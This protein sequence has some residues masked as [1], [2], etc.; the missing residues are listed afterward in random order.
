MPPFVEVAQRL[1]ADMDSTYDQNSL[2]LTNTRIVHVIVWSTGIRMRRFINETNKGYWE[3]NLYTISPS[4]RWVIT[5]EGDQLWHAQGK[6]L[7][8]QFIEI[9][10]AKTPWTGIVHLYRRRD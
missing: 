8:T 5:E 6:L 10:H 4:V 3:P 7:Q 9:A 1:K 2:V